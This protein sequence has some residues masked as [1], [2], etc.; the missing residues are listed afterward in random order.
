MTMALGLSWISV[1]IR[2]RPSNSGRPRPA[3]GEETPTSTA[4]TE[5]TCM[6]RCSPRQVHDVE[7]CVVHPPSWQ[8]AVS[9]LLCPL[10]MGT[11]L[12]RRTISPH[13][14]PWRLGLHEGSA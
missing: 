11:G 14:S 2:D 4:V 9:N 3:H 13:R 10:T 6:T 7:R 12:A 8:D 1:V 5:P